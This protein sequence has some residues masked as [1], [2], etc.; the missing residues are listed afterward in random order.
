VDLTNRA[1]E[2]ARR[3]YE[4]SLRQNGY[5]LGR[6]Q[7]VHQFGRDPQEIVTRPAR[8]DAVTP[9]TIQDVLKRK[10][11]LDRYTIVTLLPAAP[12]VAAAS[13]P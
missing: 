6:L 7:A 11:P 12:P 10:F 9:T 5:W 1:K 2:S 13:R 8:I 3:G 4:E